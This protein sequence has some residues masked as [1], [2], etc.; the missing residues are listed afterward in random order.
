MNDVPDT[1]F[2]VTKSSA[3][4][5]SYAPMSSPGFSDLIACAEGE[6]LKRQ[7]DATLQEWRKHSQ[8]PGRPIAEQEVLARRALQLREA[9]TE[10]NTAANRMYLH[11]EGCAICRRR[12]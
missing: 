1:T 11:R 9:L 7:Y 5:T 12:R 4:K 10:R 2:E 3:K 6:H 8:P